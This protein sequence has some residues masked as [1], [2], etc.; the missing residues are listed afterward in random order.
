MR[1]VERDPAENG[2][3]PVIVRPEKLKEKGPEPDRR[4]KDA[5]TNG[6]PLVEQSIVHK[7]LT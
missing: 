6:V 1:S 4:G 7:D 3:A 5:I 2:F